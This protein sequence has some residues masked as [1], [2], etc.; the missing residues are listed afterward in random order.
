MSKLLIIGC[1]GVAQVAIKKCCQNSEV[2]TDICI[3]SRTKEKCDAVKAEVDTWTKTHVT[4]AKVDADNT[5]EV[6]RQKIL[7]IKN[8]EKYTKRDVKDLDL[9]LILIIPG[10]GLIRK[11]LKRP[12]LP[13]FLEADLIRV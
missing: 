2:F 7:M 11:N 3:A 8:G 4:T 10:S 1:G 9:P 5:K 13:D 12:G 6:M